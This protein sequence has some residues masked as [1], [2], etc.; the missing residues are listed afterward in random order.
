M[1]YSQKCEEKGCLRVVSK[2]IHF[3]K[4]HKNRCPHEWEIVSSWGVYTYW[5]RRICKICKERQVAEI[6]PMGWKKEE[7]QVELSDTIP[8]LTTTL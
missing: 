7:K 1:T 8:P 2:R 4:F 6:H 5:I 3:C